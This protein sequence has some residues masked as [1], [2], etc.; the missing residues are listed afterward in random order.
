MANPLTKCEAIFRRLLAN[1]KPTALE[2][3]SSCVRTP[4]GFD[5]RQFGCIP[6]RMSKAGLIVEAGFR[7]SKSAK[8]H[9]SIN[10]LWVLAEFADAKQ[11]GQDNG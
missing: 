7:H 1:G 6:L 11:G 9:R 3:A 5:R 8:C 4:E 2:D 10:R